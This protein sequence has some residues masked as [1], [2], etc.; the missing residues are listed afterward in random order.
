MPE[1][2]TSSAAVLDPM[3]IYLHTS[4][5]AVTASKKFIYAYD[6]D[7]SCQETGLDTFKQVLDSDL[8][9]LNEYFTRWRLRSNLC[10]TKG[11][12]FLP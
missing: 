8:R 11:R 6:I 5:V 12:V 9:T 4:D 10:K 7:V 3:L 1:Q 2:R